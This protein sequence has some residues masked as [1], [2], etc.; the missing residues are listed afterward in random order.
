MKILKL[1]PYYAPEQISSTHLSNDLN[2]VFIDAGFT[3]EYFVPTPTRGI[4]DEVR[5]QYKKIK[6][7]EQEDGKII[8]H[9]FSMFREGK[10]PIQRALRY[11]FVNIAQYYKGSHAND[12][13]VIIAGSTPPTQGLLCGKVKNKLT[14][15]YGH[16]VPF[17]YSLQDVFPDSMVNAH[18]IRKG[19]L[20]WKIGRA[21]ENYTYKAATKIVVIGEDIK[22]NILEKGV[23]EDKIVVIP[24]WIDTAS[25]FP[26]DR[27][28]NTLFDELSIE[29]EKF[30]VTYAGNLGSAQGI[31][32]IIDAAEKLSENTDIQFVIFGGGINYQTIEKRVESMNNVKL[33]PLMPQERVFEVY[34]MGDMSI[35]ACKKGVGGGAIPSKTLSIMATGTP[36]LLSFDV[37][38]ELWN[39]IKD[40]SLGYTT[41]AEDVDA[42]TEAI[43]VAKEK[44]EDLSDMGQNALDYVKKNYSKEILTQKRVEMVRKIINSEH[45]N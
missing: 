28:D 40:N 31:D 3:F 37:D 35:V 16:D 33:F 43:L 27:K 4:S 18:L 10:N 30:I 19:G 34:S 6:Y 36:V 32:T 22:Q 21:I 13:D 44:P 20:I 38:S 11:V 15:R 12:I 41:P 9:R 8:V 24:N 14:K 23:D 2:K 5:Q 42:L 29:R 45:N 1:S 39:I 25:V 17:V 26:V 7:E